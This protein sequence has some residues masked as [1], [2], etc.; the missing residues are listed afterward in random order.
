MKRNETEKTETFV[1]G[2]VVSR[3]K[4]KKKTRLSKHEKKNVPVILK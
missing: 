3:T 4:E 2:D 1:K